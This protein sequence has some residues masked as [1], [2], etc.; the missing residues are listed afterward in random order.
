MK[1]MRT[2][3]RCCPKLLGSPLPQRDAEPLAR[4]FKVLADPARLR[5]LSFLASRDGL[6]ACVCELTAPLDLSQPTVSHH[7]KVLHDV[8]LVERE[9]RGAW[10]FYRLLPDRVRVLRD[11][12][13]LPG[14]TAAANV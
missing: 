8:G 6:E 5:L 3:E 14:E 10:V 7:L 13:A 2:V 1:I 11:A 9:R 12:L 4:A